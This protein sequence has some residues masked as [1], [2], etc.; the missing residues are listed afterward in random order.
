MRTAVL[1]GLLA[2]WSWGGLDK[3]I[4]AFRLQ[5]G[6]VS[7]PLPLA[8]GS[9]VAAAEASRLVAGSGEAE[10]APGY[11]AVADTTPVTGVK[12]GRP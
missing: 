6:G 8:G 10:A 11:P 2:V 7:S 3:R 9:I 12:A 4:A 5:A 1:L